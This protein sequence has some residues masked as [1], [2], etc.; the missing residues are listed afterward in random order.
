MRRI[1]SRTCRTIPSWRS[2]RGRHPIFRSLQSLL[3]DFPLPPRKIARIRARA[4]L[5]GQYPAG[6]LG[7]APCAQA[8]RT[9]PPRGRPRRAGWQDRGSSRPIPHGAARRCRAR[10]WAA[11]RTRSAFPASPRRDHEVETLSAPRSMALLRPFRRA[12]R[13]GHARIQSPRASRS[14]RG[15]CAPSRRRG[16]GSRGSTPGR[17]AHRRC[18]RPL[19]GQ[20]C[21]FEQQPLIPP[22]IHAFDP[23]RRRFRRARAAQVD[24]LPGSRR[25]NTA[26]PSGSASS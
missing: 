3:I 8:E 12:R 17:R 25:S 16:N 18:D 23:L 1:P 5:N 22:Q 14:T 4:A 19:R 21:V 9:T 20:P 10:G 7:F 24:P 26:S 6:Q 11:S 13:D 2:R 15:R